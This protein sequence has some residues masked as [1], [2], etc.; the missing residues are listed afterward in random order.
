MEL[1][2]SFVLMFC[3][4]QGQCRSFLNV[5]RPVSSVPT[6]HP[7]RTS[8]SSL[9]F[10]H[11]L[12]VF[13]GCLKHAGCVYPMVCSSRG[14]FFP[15]M[16]SVVLVSSSVLASPGTR[17]CLGGLSMSATPDLA[18]VLGSNTSVTGSPLFA[19]HVVEHPLPSW[20]CCYVV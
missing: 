18:L 14:L 3:V 5:L 4:A 20:S 16:I 11:R 2:P 1:P 13:R 8:A 12:G 6:A 7:L 15:M 10:C 19:F 17:E 9:T